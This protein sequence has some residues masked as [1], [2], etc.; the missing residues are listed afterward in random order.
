MGKR[1]AVGMISHE[2]NCFSPMPTP[3]PAW[4]ERSYII[5]QE[6]LVDH[7][8]KKTNFGGFMEIAQRE[9][10]E[11]LPTL[12]ASAVPSAPTDAATY[13]HLKSLLLDPLRGQKLDGVWLAMHGAMA[14]E[15]VD[16]PELDIVLEARR[17]IGNIPLVVTLDLHG[18]LQKE[19]VENCD[20]IFGFDTNPH[21][22]AYERAKEAGELLSRMLNE[23]I[24]PVTAFT[25]GSMMPP[26]INQRTA[27]GP[28]ATLF[29]K[30][31]EHEA[32]PG[33]YNV[34]VFGGFPYVDAP[35]SG[36]SVVTTAAELS[37]AQKVSDEIAAFAWEIRDEFMKDIP[38]IHTALD[39]A[40]AHLDE[41]DT[42][43][44]ILTDVADNPGG[45]G[46]GDTPELLRELVQRNLPGSAA[47][48]FWDP[49]TVREAIRTG[50]G[51]TGK[52]RIGGKACAD[53]GPPVEVEAYVAAISDGRFVA[54][55]PMMRG[56]KLDLGLA[57]RLV[58]GNVQ[59]LIGSVRQAC[60]DA[61][62]FRNLGVEPARERVLLIKS[63]GH[64]RASF[65][66]LSKM[67]IE[68]DAP[69]AVN[70]NLKRFPYKRAN[71][72]PLNT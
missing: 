23:G 44:I 51:N 62:I 31:R 47:A 45:G 30:A 70:T 11:L 6:I 49:E 35:Y 12:A 67:I 24:K 21:V 64:F 66:P 2:S 14:A 57:V 27:E 9:G 4:K 58:V 28:M 48:L 59:I 1:I 16:D 65:E 17:I 36:L 15:G 43:P 3:L 41:S 37:L 19:M 39:M 22:D 5:G 42:R 60:N 18:N 72:W 68:V 25:H 46:S 54:T 55:G 7:E 26:T 69:G 10:W 50:V 38:D 32:K 40:E 13:N 63:R 8:G 20:A 29:A 56:T 34:S 52:F 71:R 33:I 61:D 53:Y